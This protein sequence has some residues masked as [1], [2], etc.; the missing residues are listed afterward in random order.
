[1][2]KETALL[3]I[4]ARM[5]GTSFRRIAELMG[6]DSKQSTGMDIVGEASNILGI[7]VTTLDSPSFGQNIDTLHLQLGIFTVE[8]IAKKILTG[9]AEKEK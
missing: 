6:E 5:L 3:V 1:M 8:E 4:H 2:D 7:D 9:V